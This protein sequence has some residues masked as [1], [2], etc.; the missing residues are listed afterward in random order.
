MTSHD[1]AIAGAT[2]SGLGSTHFSARNSL[3]ASTCPLG[4]TTVWI[5]AHPQCFKVR[6]TPV[7]AMLRDRRS[8][9]LDDTARTDGS[10]LR[11][12]NL[13]TRSVP[14]KSTAVISFAIPDFGLLKSQTSLSSVRQS[15]GVDDLRTPVLQSM[16]LPSLRVF[17]LSTRINGPAALFSING[18]DLLRVFGLLRSQISNFTLLP[19]AFYPKAIIH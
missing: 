10:D 13:R 7:P 2:K 5:A 9:D 19:N 17:D 15:S 14:L 8:R 12:S 3:R 1:H 18:R 11:L 6:T 4:K 16:V